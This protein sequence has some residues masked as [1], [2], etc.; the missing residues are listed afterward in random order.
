MFEETVKKLKKNLVPIVN[1]L[2]GNSLPGFDKVPVYYVG[3]YF[4]E[5]TW[6]GTLGTR[7]ASLAFNFFLCSATL[8]NNFSSQR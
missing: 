2:K 1:W 8:L 5:A 6:N 7:S 4:K 3:Y